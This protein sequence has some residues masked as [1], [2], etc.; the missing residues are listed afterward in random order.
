MPYLH[1]GQ[2]V[3]VEEKRIIGIFD[4]DNTTYSKHTRNFLDGAEA[5]G[6]VISVCED[7]PRSFLLCDHPYHKQIIYLSQLNTATL[8]KRAEGWK[9][10][11][12]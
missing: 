12:K 4:L 11:L 9:E 7:I 6:Q 3:T 2:S 5:E 8:Q 10:E 1:I